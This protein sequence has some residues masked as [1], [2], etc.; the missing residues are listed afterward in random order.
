MVARKKNEPK[1]TNEAKKAVADYHAD[2]E[3]L[4]P[5]PKP[6][7]ALTEDVRKLDEPARV[8]DAPEAIIPADPEGKA[9][10]GEASE[11]EL[12]AAARAVRREGQRP[13]YYDLNAVAKDLQRGVPSREAVSNNRTQ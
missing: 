3:N 1:L 10:G 4:V 5:E 11:A 6:A 13:Q 12:Y 8:D 7:P 2:P 9:K